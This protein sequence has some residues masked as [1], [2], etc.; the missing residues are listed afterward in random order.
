MCLLFQRGL[1]LTRDRTPRPLLGARIGVRALA[2]HGQSL[3]MT[4]P[5][6]RPDV[7]QP[8][9]VHR[10]L[11]V[12][13]V[14]HASVR[15][16]PGL[17]ED[18]PRVAGADAVDVRKGVLNLLVARQIHAGY[19]RHALPLPLLVLGCALADD[20][21]DALPLYHLAV[22]ANRLDAGSNLHRGRPPEMKNFQLNREQ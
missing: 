15:A 12:P 4:G 6:I 19:A 22:L 5:P 10:D 9:D 7:H 17:R 14:A 18:L 2:A 16:D 8:L 11:G 1:L 21:A 3:A 13:Q 20:A